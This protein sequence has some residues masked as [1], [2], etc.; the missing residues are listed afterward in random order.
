MNY[1]PRAE[2]V[3]HTPQPVGVQDIHIPKDALM[4]FVL[5]GGDVDAAHLA[6]AAQGEGA[7]TLS[8]KGMTCDHCANTIRETVSAILGVESAEVNLAQGTAVVSGRNLDEASI[9]A[10][11]EKL[12]YKAATTV[13]P[14]AF[15][16]SG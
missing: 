7:V 6:A 11:I 4:P 2:F 10:A 15:R 16:R 8:V 1:V 12:G 14:T 9:C 13:F 3:Q 5:G